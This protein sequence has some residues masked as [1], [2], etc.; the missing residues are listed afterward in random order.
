MLELSDAWKKYIPH[1]LVMFIK[2]TVPHLIFKSA[3]NKGK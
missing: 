3:L 2:K 1:S